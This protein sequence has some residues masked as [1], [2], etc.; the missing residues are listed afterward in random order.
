MGLRSKLGLYVVGFVA[1]VLGLVGYLSLRAETNIYLEEMKSRGVALLRAFA[2]PATVAMANNDISTLD[3]YVV[4]FAG[5]AQS[6]DLRYLA[7]LDHD[8]RVVAHTTAGEFGKVYDD[9]FMRE[10]AGSQEPLSRMQEVDGEQVLEVAVPA[11]SGLRWGTLRAG[12]SLGSVERA[13][14]QSRQRLLLSGLAVLLGSAIIAYAVLSFLVVRPVVR[15]RGMARRFGAGELDARVSLDQR[16]E[17]GELATQLNRMAQQIQNYTTSLEELV[18]DR[19]AELAAANEKLLAVNEQ[20]DTLART[21]GLTGLYNRRHF[22]EQLQFEIRRGARTRH[23]F[24]LIL[25][26]VD[27]F[28]N[29]NDVNG[30]TAGDELLQRLAALLQIN[31]RATDVVA[32]YGGEEFIILLLDTGPEEGYGTARKL[33]QVVAAQPL[34]HDENQPA[35]KVTISV[36]VAFYPQDSV[37]GRTLIEY[38]DQALYFS[39]QSGRNRVSR[40][41][42]MVKT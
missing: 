15:M 12:F 42:Q 21:D 36:G 35:G 30:H 40:W 24:T 38:A 5:A 8:N 14:L 29:Y 34:P 32:R 11:V 7:V 4:Q 10:A 9:P 31:L 28:K 22:M 20:L 17:M 2:I 41:T 26:D 13:L 1:T 19:T 25:L 6:L 27:H 3:N 37:D 39:K 18:Q 23:Q 16:D 33:Q